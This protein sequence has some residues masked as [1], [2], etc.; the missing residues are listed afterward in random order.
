MDHIAP[1]QDDDNQ[2]FHVLTEGHDS[3]S[4]EEQ[5]QSGQDVLQQASSSPPVPQADSP[6]H[7]Q[8]TKVA[9]FSLHYHK[10]I[11]S[12]TPPPPRLVALNVLRACTVKVAL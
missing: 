9:V 5:I 1:D 8:W 7:Q 4:N 6:R 3:D 12:K 2:L 11:Q 10:S